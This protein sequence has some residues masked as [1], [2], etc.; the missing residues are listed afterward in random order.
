M[1]SLAFRLRRI[2]AGVQPPLQH[3][4]VVSGGC[5]GPAKESSSLAFPKVCDSFPSLLN[6]EVRYVG[7]CTNLPGGFKDGLLRL[8]RATV[9]NRSLRPETKSNVKTGIRNDQKLAWWR[10]DYPPGTSRANCGA[11]QSIA[12]SSIPAIQIRC[13]RDPRQRGDPERR[14]P[15]APGR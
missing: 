6:G 13:W 9:H 12:C 14:Q 8:T 5:A 10:G 15:P 2:F 7:E 3:P 4:Y 1:T 11:K